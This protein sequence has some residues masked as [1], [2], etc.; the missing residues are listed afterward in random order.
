M[1]IAFRVDPATG[2]SVSVWLGD[3]TTEEVMRH[4]RELWATP[5]WASGGRILTDLT[6][7]SSSALPDPDQVGQLASTFADL[8]EGR[9]RPASWA[10]VANLGYMRASQFADAIQSDVRR[11]LAFFDLAPACIWLGVDLDAMRAA[12]ESLR[13]EAQQRGQADTD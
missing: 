8:M 6:Q 9:T 11:V 13:I 5:D 1:G 2:T 4:V 7:V 10:L 12:V 3:I